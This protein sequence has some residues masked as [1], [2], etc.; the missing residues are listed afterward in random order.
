MEDDDNY[1]EMQAD[2]TLTSALQNA[3]SKA[4]AATVLVADKV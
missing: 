2:P 1:S 4:P 3:A